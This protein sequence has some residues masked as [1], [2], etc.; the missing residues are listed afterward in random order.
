[1]TCIA[2][3]ERKSTCGG[4][5]RSTEQPHGYW[6]PSKAP[7]RSIGIRSTG[8][9]PQER[10][11]KDNMDSNDINE[12]AKA[13]KVHRYTKELIDDEYDYRIGRYAAGV[14]EKACSQTLSDT[15][16]LDSLLEGMCATFADQYHESP[17]WDVALDVLIDSIKEAAEA[18]RRFLKDISGGDPTIES[19]YDS[20]PEVIERPHCRRCVECD[21]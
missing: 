16:V 18:H 3:Q 4:P 19:F 20:I 5:S 15:A 7:L 2:S 8:D 10:L 12:V 6:I 14:V 9:A 1:M 13:T 11:D 17:Q 21:E